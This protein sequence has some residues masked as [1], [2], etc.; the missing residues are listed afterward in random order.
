MG[1]AAMPTSARCHTTRAEAALC[2]PGGVAA[3]PALTLRT[4]GGQTHSSARCYS[5]PQSRRP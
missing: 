3:A 5:D 2:W 1:A 4:R